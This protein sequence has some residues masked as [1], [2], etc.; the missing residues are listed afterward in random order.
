MGDGKGRLRGRRAT[1]LLV[2]AM[3]VATL[4][5]GICAATA[6]AGADDVA[7]VSAPTTPTTQ[8]APASAMPPSPP[9]PSQA[10]SPPATEAAPEPSPAPPAPEPSPAPPSAAIDPV[11]RA[12]A[13]LMSIE[14]GAWT[15][16]VP[17]RIE[18]IGG[19][20]SW[21]ASNGVIYIPTD[22]AAGDWTMLVVTLGHEWGHL[23]AYWFGAQTYLGAPPDGFPADVAQ[24]VEQWADCVSQVLTGVARPSHGLPP[25]RPDSLAF[26]ADFLA[27]GPH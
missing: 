20:A 24:P 4:V 2:T 22:V 14:P 9:A 5:G 1:Q 19:S 11:E 26:T 13:A 18:M 8:P 17:Y 16:S 3:I 10:V 21:A 25:C 7:A 23:V 12:T 27:N 6:S 15:S